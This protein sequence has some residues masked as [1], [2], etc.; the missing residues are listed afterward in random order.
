MI[1]IFIIIL[2]C[3]LNLNVYAFSLNSWFENKN[4]R[5]KRLMA[6]EQYD[7]AAEAFTRDDWRAVAAYRGQNY[8][9]AAQQFKALNTAEGFYNAGN[10]LAQQGQYEAA[11]KAYDETLKREPNHEDAK[12]NRELLKKMNENQKKDQDQDQNQEN[13]NKENQSQANQQQDKQNN[14]E[15][16]QQDEGQDKESKPSESQQK[17][18]PEHN[19]ENQKNQQDEPSQA[20]PKD[21]NES[22]GE[23]KT[24]PSESKPEQNDENN[25]VLR[26]VP[27]DPGGLLREKFWRDHWRR[28]QKE[29]Q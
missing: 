26:L 20:S 21:S 28:L 15:N 29:R 8:Q 14:P 22:P 24:K 10:A 7:S 19:Q 27:D 4:Q 17:E 13:Q 9:A 23:Q 1:R 6:N 2:A 25:R 16:Q 12:F 11:I 5:A 18:Q 3:T